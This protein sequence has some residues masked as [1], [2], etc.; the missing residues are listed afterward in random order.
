MKF[1]KGDKFRID[2][3]KL[4][5]ENSH[6]GPDYVAYQRGQQAH[7]GNQVFVATRVFKGRFG[8]GYIINFDYPDQP[9]IHSSIGVEYAMKGEV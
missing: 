2:W 9:G 7:Y 6:T 4:I 1:K 5:K 3:E 8:S